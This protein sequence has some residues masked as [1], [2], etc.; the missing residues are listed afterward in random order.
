[1]LG[2]E[3]WHGWILKEGTTDTQTLKDQLIR[4]NYFW[5]LEWHQLDQYSISKYISIFF[6][7]TVTL[8]FVIMN[9]T[10]QTILRM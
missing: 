10:N 7:L 2:W 5:I 1:M 9:I 6:Y 4:S 8:D 3:R